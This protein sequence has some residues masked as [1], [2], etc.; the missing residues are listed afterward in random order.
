MLR[1]ESDEAALD[2]YDQRRRAAALEVLKFT[3]RITRVATLRSPVA[4][5]VRRLLARTVGRSARVKRH[6]A[7]WVTGLER[8]PLRVDQPTA[9]PQLR[10][11]PAPGQVIAMTVHHFQGSRL[12]KNG[13]LIL[14][15]GFGGAHVAR[16]LG[17]PG[18]TVVSPE[19]SM[20]YTPLLPEVAAGVIEPGTRSCRSG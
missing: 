19:S 4:R 9:A 11:L 12:A 14:G 10:R 17:Q 18:A 20:L 1:G 3:D 15:G 7:M 2:L 5:G 8:S 16:L 6:V 13:T